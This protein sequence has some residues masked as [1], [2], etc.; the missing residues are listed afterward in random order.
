VC[1]A[2]WASPHC[3]DPPAA[4]DE[5]EEDVVG[6]GEAV[7]ESDAP[8]RSFVTRFNTPLRYVAGWLDDGG[9][10]SIDP[11]AGPSVVSLS[12][13]STLDVTENET[14]LYRLPMYSSS[15]TVVGAAYLISYRTRQEQP[16]SEWR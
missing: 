1:C 7:G 9:V 10:R 5:D 8:T 6:C 14:L 11:A 3:A 12:S 15:T 13:S 2:D 16:T 4:V